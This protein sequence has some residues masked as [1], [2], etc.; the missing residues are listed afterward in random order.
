MLRR[1]SRIQQ[2]RMYFN[3]VNVDNDTT[4]QSDGYCVMAAPP[5]G[6]TA[7]T[8]FSVIEEPKEERAKADGYC[9]MAGVS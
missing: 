3:G 5:A 1:Y 2:N 4:G 9:V 7:D 6:T 8:L